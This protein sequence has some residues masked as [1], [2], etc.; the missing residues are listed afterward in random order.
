MKTFYQ[1]LSLTLAVILYCILRMLIDYNYI[2]SLKSFKIV[3][4]P[5]KLVYISGVDSELD[6][7]GGIVEYQDGSHGEKNLSMNVFLQENYYSLVIV[8]EY[9]NFDNPGVEVITFKV[10]IDEPGAYNRFPVQV[11]DQQFIDDIVKCKTEGIC[12]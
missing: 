8:E 7:S 3:E 6:L 5:D 11:I 2:N 9:I 10:K 4:P 12:K 1:I